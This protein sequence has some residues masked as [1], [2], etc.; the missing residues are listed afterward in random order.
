MDLT[1]III[2]S[3]QRV[4]NNLGIGHSEKIYH[5]GLHAELACLGFNLTSEYHLAVC[6]TDSRGGEHILESERIDIFI[7]KDPNSNYEELHGG[8]IILELKSIKTL[9]NAESIQIHKY[10]NELNKKG[11][12]I[13]YGLI[14]N[15]PKDKPEIDCLK[16]ENK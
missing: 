5:K 10:F 14:I 1:R 12:N 2:D 15:F 6:Y 13:G 9:G 3:A 11:I 16:I 4:L 8:H 7:H